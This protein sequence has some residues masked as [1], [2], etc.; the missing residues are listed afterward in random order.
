VNELKENKELEKY[1]RGVLAKAVFKYQIPGNFTK[2]HSCI[3]F[4]TNL[5]SK[6]M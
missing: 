1:E 3:I 6:Y 5:T 4:I 2:L